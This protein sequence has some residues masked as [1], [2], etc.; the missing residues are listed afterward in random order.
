MAAGELRRAHPRRAAEQF[1]GLIRGDL[2]LRSMLG[3]EADVAQ[4]AFDTVL[5]SGVDTFYRA[6]GLDRA[7]RGV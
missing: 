7:M 2:Q 1:V 3:V 5:R 6:Y 4:T